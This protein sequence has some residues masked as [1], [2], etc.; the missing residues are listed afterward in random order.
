MNPFCENIDYD[1]VEAAVWADDIKDQAMNFWD[2]W[3]FYDLPINPSG[4]ILV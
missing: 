3:H 2:N 4:E 1:F